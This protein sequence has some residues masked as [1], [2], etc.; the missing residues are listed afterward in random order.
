[1]FLAGI[2]KNNAKLLLIALEKI[3]FYKLSFM[4]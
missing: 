1:M 4:K 2:Q 3:L